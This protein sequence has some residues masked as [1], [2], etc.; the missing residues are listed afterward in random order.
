MN[1]WCRVLEAHQE[2]PWWPAADLEP[3][4]Y[5]YV[6]VCMYA[7]I[8]IYGSTSRAAAA[9]LE[10]PVY[11]CVYVC[12]HVCVFTCMEAPCPILSLGLRVSK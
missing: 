8:C 3:P 7:D 2:L 1:E 12:M 9:D 11:I 5:V 4:V 6:Y 10:S